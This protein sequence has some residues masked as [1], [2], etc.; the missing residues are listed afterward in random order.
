MF[1]FLQLLHCN[2]IDELDKRIL[3]W[4]L[5]LGGDFFENKFLFPETV[6]AAGLA[7]GPICCQHFANCLL[8]PSFVFETRLQPGRLNGSWGVYKVLYQMFVFSSAFSCSNMCGIWE[9]SLFLAV[10]LPRLFLKLI[11]RSISSGNEAP[12][13]NPQHFNLHWVCFHSIR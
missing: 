6:Q 2:E 11:S 10:A 9:N 13:P 12:A 5:E 7:L 8:L 3:K 1:H 4:K